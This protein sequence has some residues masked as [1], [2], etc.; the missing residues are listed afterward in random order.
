MTRNVD[1]EFRFF[2]CHFSFVIADRSSA[3]F[4]G[5]FAQSPRPLNSDVCDVM[6]IKPHLVFVAFLLLIPSASFA[7]TCA[8][9][10]L[11]P[12]GRPVKDQVE[13][14]RKESEA[15]FSGVVTRIVFNKRAKTYEAHFKVYRS[16]KG[17][18]REEV[19]VFGVMVFPCVY[20]FKISE[21]YLVSAYGSEIEGTKRLSASVCGRTKFLRYADEDM[22]LLGKG[23][24]VGKIKVAFSGRRSTTTHST[25]PMVNKYVYPS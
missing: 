23:K 15:I 12:G 17:V 22:K 24:A 20:T 5:L 14:A 21:K 2:I 13:S 25:L 16:W 3:P 9:E 7:C 11:F 4:Q 8:D 1:S 10:S 19:N 18:D 6:K